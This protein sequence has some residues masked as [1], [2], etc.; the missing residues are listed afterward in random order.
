MT[1]IAKAT[2]NE[3]SPKRSQPQLQEEIQVIQDDDNVDG[4]QQDNNVTHDDGYNN[5]SDDPE[6]GEAGPSTAVPRSSYVQGLINKQKT[7][8]ENVNAQKSPTNPK[9]F[10]FHDPQPD[11]TSVEWDEESQR[12]SQGATS[13]RP[14]QVTKEKRRRDN[15][16]EEE[17]EEDGV[18]QDEGFETDNRALPATARRHQTSPKRKRVEQRERVGSAEFRPSV[19]PSAS[20]DDR[21]RGLERDIRRTN[22]N[23]RSS[24]KAPMSIRPKPMQQRRAWSRDE[25]DALIEYIETY[26]TGWADIKTMDNGNWNESTESWEGPLSLE[27][28]D[29]VALKDKARNLRV[30]YHK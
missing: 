20:Q 6:Q 9:P 15:D 24:A 16:I 28:R 11:A 4:H 14:G 7:N 2:P 27:G 3:L 13:R 18:S 23:I 10:R 21:S 26:G 5:L 25:E 30:A 29:Q 22:S 19:E 12:A 8:K 1:A 17:E